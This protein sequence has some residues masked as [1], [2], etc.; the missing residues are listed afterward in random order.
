ME[1]PLKWQ[2]KPLQVSLGGL[3]ETAPAVP[4]PGCLASR[5]SPVAHLGR[6]YGRFPT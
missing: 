1:H 6:T 2:G 5:G 3:A 4:S